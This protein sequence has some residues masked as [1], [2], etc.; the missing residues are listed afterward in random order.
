MEKLNHKTGHNIS[1]DEWLH[2]LDELN[3]GAFTVNLN[4]QI[5]AINRCAQ[6]LIGLH[7]QEVLKGDCRE[8]FTGVPCMVQ[9][10]IS[11]RDNP[12]SVDTDVRVVDEDGQQQLITR[13]ATPTVPP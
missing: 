10:L 7:D 8:I 11:H 6:A 9:C 4:H 2:I 1:C 5:T 13:M 3:I 12:A